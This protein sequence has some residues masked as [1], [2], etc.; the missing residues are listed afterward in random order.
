MSSD[1]R[2]WPISQHCLDQSKELGFD[3][4][5]PDQMIATRNTEAEEFLALF[6]DHVGN[7]SKL[8][9]RLMISIAA[10]TI[11]L[12][13]PNEANA[14]VYAVPEKRGLEVTAPIL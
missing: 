8:R 3:P 5:I 13:V 2:R 9:S 12:A 11:A 10:A 7:S 4:N 6:Q 1:I 14:D